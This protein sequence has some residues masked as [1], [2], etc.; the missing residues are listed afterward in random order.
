VTGGKFFE[1]AP[2]SFGDF[3][4]TDASTENEFAPEVIEDAVGQA[5][6]DDTAQGVSER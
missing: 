5:C 6:G 4:G 3:E 1:S 2:E